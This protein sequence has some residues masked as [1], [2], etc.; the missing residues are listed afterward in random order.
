M[1]T[2]KRTPCK[3]TQKRRGKKHHGGT[4]P[5]MPDNG[6]AKINHIIGELKLKHP[7][8]SLKRAFSN[9]KSDEVKV[10]DAATVT[11]IYKDWRKVEAA[12]RRLNRDRKNE[13]NLP[14]QQT[15]KPRKKPVTKRKRSPD[16][17]TDAETDDALMLFKKSNNIDSIEDFH[18]ATTE[19]FPL[20]PGALKTIEGD[21]YNDYRFTPKKDR[22]N[23]KPHI[24]STPTDLF[25]L[26]PVDLDNTAENEEDD[27]LGLLE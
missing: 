4:T 16:K 9:Y 6:Q 10:M 23:R 12:A 24:T 21:T 11:R 3:I 15:V 13:A 22:D 20:S 1:K 19:D 27:V 14:N 8:G 17:I 2:K 25:K 7:I 18:D 5:R 26:N